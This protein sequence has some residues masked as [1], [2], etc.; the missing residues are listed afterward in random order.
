MQAVDLLAVV[1]RLAASSPTYLHN[2]QYHSETDVRPLA[3]VLSLAEVQ[4]T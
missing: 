1:P 2:T 4:E 3:I